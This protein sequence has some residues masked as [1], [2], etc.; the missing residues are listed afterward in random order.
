MK[1]YLLALVSSAILLGACTATPPADIVVAIQNACIV[2]AGL[3]PV[4]KALQLALA[5]PIESLA[6]DSARSVID[7][8]CANPAGSINAN[9]MT[10]LAT[11][12]GNIES[13]VVTLEARKGAK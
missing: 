9:T 6:L 3:R 5:N 12:I 11:N 4:A 8:I 7:P 2:D 1:K 10:I 13:I